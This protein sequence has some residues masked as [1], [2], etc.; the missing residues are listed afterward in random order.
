MAGFTPNEHARCVQTLFTTVVLERTKPAFG[1]PFSKS[2]E[3]I[4]PGSLI[5]CVLVF[6]SSRTATKGLATEKRGATF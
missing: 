4:S 3:N 2:K 1:L 5:M 6:A